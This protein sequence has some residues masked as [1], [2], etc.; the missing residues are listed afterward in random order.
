M[1]RLSQKN[2]RLAVIDSPW[3]LESRFSRELGTSKWSAGEE[4]LGC[5]AELNPARYLCRFVRRGFRSLFSS[6][7]SALLFYGMW[8][9]PW[10]QPSSV[11]VAAILGGGAVVPFSLLAWSAVD[12][13]KWKVTPG[14]GADLCLVS[15]STSASLEELGQHSVVYPLAPL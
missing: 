11:A 8:G 1:F 12:G 10:G 9:V 3:L 7:P 6:F 14:D 15:V 5:P 13:G 2:M 4:G